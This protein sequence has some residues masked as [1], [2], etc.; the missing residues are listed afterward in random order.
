MLPETDVSQI[1]VGDN[2]PV[3]IQTFSQNFGCVGSGN[4]REDKEYQTQ[5]PPGMF[6]R[7]WKTQ[8]TNTN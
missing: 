7:Q 5:N 6:H 2:A 8:Q 1:S 4:C 3:D